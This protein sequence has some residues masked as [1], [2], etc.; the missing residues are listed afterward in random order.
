MKFNQLLEELK[1]GKFQPIYFLHGTESYF[2]D[3]I[4]DYIEL[5]ALEDSEK[6]FNQT[7]LYGKDIDHLAVMDTARR[8]PMMASRQLVIIKEAQEMKS[9]KELKS[10][11]EQPSE[12]TLLVICHKHKKFNLNTSFGKA[13]KKNAVVFESKSPYDNEMPGWITQY[14]KQKKLSIKTEVAALIA[15][16]LGKDLSKVANELDKLSVNLPSGS[17]VTTKEVEE[18]IGISKD[19]NIFELQKALGMRDVEKVGRIIQYF[20][21]NPKRNPMPVVISSLYNYF[22]KIYMLHF[23]RNKSDSEMLTAL[24]LRSAYFLKDYKFALKNYS[25]PSTEAT[26]GYLYEYDLKSK[27][28]DFNNTGKSDSALL[29]ELTWKILN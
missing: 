24:N 28:V 12:T 1:G 25:L 15:E 10:Y 3:H 16:Y 20:A 23:L 21:S 14:L 18:N 17:E 29:K 8:Y 9:L 22:S 2:I 26:L 4:A 6:A 19:Y 5:N 27:G 13:L 11:V 7:I